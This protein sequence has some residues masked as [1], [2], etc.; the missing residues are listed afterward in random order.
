[1][2]YVKWIRDYVGPQKIF[3]VYS[4]VILVDDN[5]RFL[6]QQRTDFDV[7]G[8]PGGVLE[9]NEDIRQCAHRELMEETGLSVGKFKLVGIYTHPHFDVEYPNGD[10]VQQ[11][12]VCLTG[13]LTGG[14]MRP[15]GE[16]T[17]AQAFLAL[18]E[19]EN[20]SILPWYSVM[21]AD[22]VRGGLPSFTPPF[23][24][25]VVQDQI[26]GLRQFVGHERIIA[27][28]ATTAVYR[29]DGRF[30]MIQRADN[31]MWVFPAGYAD[32]GENA[33][34]TAVRETFEETGYHIEP[35]RIL[36][37]YS[38]AHYHHTFPN[39]DQVKNVGTLF[40]S[41]LVGGEP[42]IQTSEVKKI[43]WLTR[44]EV[45]QRSSPMLRRLHEEAL[46]CMDNG[47]CFID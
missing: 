27:V 8:L 42:K 40:L 46:N 10:Q 24:N 47:G 35:E 14:E 41:R 18:S 4:T 15:D 21:L 16:E 26:A 44:K 5:G 29:E 23:S 36:A 28:G 12:T 11:Y 7:W 34:Q 25:E 37:I 6:V 13:R 1:M 20:L 38:S 39:G 19:A 45:I 43:A 30:L 9:I 17:S 32:L 31:G 3:L 22:A 2:S 33:A